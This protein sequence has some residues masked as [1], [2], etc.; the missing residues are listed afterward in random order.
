[1]K[2]KTILTL[3]EQIKKREIKIYD[4]VKKTIDHNLKIKNLNASL[5]NNYEQALNQASFLDQEISNNDTQIDYLFGIP[6]SLKDNISTKNIITTG[7]SLFLENYQ[8]PYDATVKTLLDQNQAILLNKSNLD[9]FG[10]GGTG[11]DSAFGIVVNPLDSTRVCGGSSSGSAVLVQQGVVPFAIATDTG[12]SIRRPASIMG[13][14]G[15]KP[16]YG[17]ISRYGVYPFAPSL[18]H[19]GIFTNNVLD[20]QI[21]FNA[22]AKR[23]FK[24]FTSLDFKTQ[25]LTTLKTNNKYKI[26]IFKPSFDL[27][28]PK[29]QQELNNLINKLNKDHEVIS[30]DY[31]INL[32]KA[33]SPVYKLVA[34]SEAYSSYSNFTNITFGKHD[35][36]YKN[37]EDLIIKARTLY[38]GTQLKQRFMIGA[39][40]TQEAQFETLLTAAKKMRTLIVQKAKQLFTNCDLILNLAVHDVSETIEDVN[41]QKP[42]TNLV[43]DVMQIANFGGFPSIVIPFIKTSL[44]N[45]GLNLWADYLNDNKLLNAAYL[46]S[47]LL[48]NEEK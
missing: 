31:D 36:E 29:Y 47:N 5:A 23:D 17:I 44:G 19:V 22:I 7:G 27:L 4:L 2:N 21:V 9:E 8:P 25:S 10:L 41:N 14:V 34:F 28:E 3:H 42:T 18:D 40:V 48:G 24:D 6:Y 38:L 26:G 20:T 32:L 1:M 37:Y 33:I 12:D 43:E 39:Y 46:I 30:V 15:F 16:S 35:I 11:T 13:I 45:L